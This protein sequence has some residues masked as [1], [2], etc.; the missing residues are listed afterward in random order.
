MSTTTDSDSIPMLPPD[1]SPGSSVSS[2]LQDEYQELLQY[3]VVTPH[4]DPSQLPQTLAGA[5]QAFQPQRP[6][7]DQLLYLDSTE[8][9]ESGSTS[10]A[11][12]HLEESIVATHGSLN[13]EET[14][15][16]SQDEDGR[17]GERKLRRRDLTARLPDPSTPSRPPQQL[18]NGHLNQS[19]EYSTPTSDQS[20]LTNESAS[21]GSPALDQDIVRMERMLD[22]WSLELKRSVLAELSQ[23]KIAV[24]ERHRLDVRLLKERHQKDLRQLQNEIEGQKELLHTYEQS[25][26]RKDQIISN[27]TRAVQ[28]EKDRFEMLRRFESWKL[29]HSEDRRQ[30]FTAK[31]ATQHRERQLK[32]KVWSAWHSIIVAKWRQRVEKACQGKAQEVCM[33]LTND[34]EARIASSNEA[35]EASRV[36]VTKL[37]AERDHYEEAMK[38]AFMRGVCALNMEA[39]SMFHETEGG[40][41]GGGGPTQPPPSSSSHGGGAA[42]APMPATAAPI[43]TTAPTRPSPLASSTLRGSGPGGQTMMNSHAPGSGRMVTSHQGST[44]HTTVTQTHRSG[45]STT[46]KTA[47]G[48]TSQS[49]KT[50]TARVSG[51]SDLHASSGLGGV[52]L[53]PPMASVVVERHHPITQQTI[54]HATAA[55]YPMSAQSLPSHPSG[56]SSRSG[57]GLQTR[58]QPMSGGPTVKVVH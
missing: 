51:R 10:E 24:I 57:V 28:K 26:E 31:L 4:Y 33:K 25:V 44:P 54:G 34:Y 18:V 21:P 20:T 43:H 41:V 58:K 46:R 56:V 36:E 5:A 50:I 15:T 27:L 30:A 39:M 16:E 1:D 3:A 14:P 9:E 40:G 38:K 45:S 53:N 13:E 48:K 11:S 23:S 35:L 49:S 2:A 32:S 42:A 52:G 29:R 22:S 6:I 37:H 8:T 12:A 19:D 7:K 17:S 55:R 47:G